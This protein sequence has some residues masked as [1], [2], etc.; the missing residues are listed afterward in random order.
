MSTVA[1][2]TATRPTA[3][4][5]RR[6]V[7]IGGYRSSR[8]GGSLALLSP[9]LRQA[10]L[11]FVGIWRLHHAI[12]GEAA[13]QL[14]A[15]AGAQR[16]VP[17]VPHSLQLQCE[18]AGRAGQARAEQAQGEPAYQQAWNAVMAQCVAVQCRAMRCVCVCSL[19]PRAKPC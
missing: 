11:Q 4:G 5:R 18:E 6:N 1:T 9:A 13:A 2:T 12:E 14:D 8:S 7:A 10:R 3:G 19:K 16:I 15:A 17:K